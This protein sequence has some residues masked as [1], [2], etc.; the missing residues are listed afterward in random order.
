M[1][2]FILKG[3]YNRDE[4]DRHYLREWGVPPYSRT[5]ATHGYY[6]TLI[7]TMIYLIMHLSW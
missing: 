3:I 6:I 1:I 4:K 7:E 2:Y 5:I